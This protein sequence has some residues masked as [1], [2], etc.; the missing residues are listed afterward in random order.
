MQNEARK[1]R[2][3]R[4]SVTE[5]RRFLVVL[6]DKTLGLCVSVFELVEQGNLRHVV[7][8]GPVVAVGVQVAKTLFGSSRRLYTRDTE[9]A[10]CTGRGR[11]FRRKLNR[12]AFRNEGFS[13]RELFI[14]L[15]GE[16]VQACKLVITGIA[17]I[18]V[19]RGRL[20]VFYAHAGFEGVRGD[21]VQLRTQAV[22]HINHVVNARPVK[23]LAKVGN[24]RAVLFVL[25][26]RHG[27]QPFGQGLVLGP[28]CRFVYG[29]T[30]VFSVRVRVCVTGDIPVTKI[31]FRNLGGCNFYS[32][33][34]G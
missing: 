17:E 2:G 5:K 22:G 34:H 29:S 15:F 24:R 9:T 26:V 4:P 30:T 14:K 1:R 16:L 12:V 28:C 18:R 3:D 10:Y 7:G 21:T 13:E 31:L 20:R 33:F 11:K 27:K 23:P 19:K 32:C 25:T 6:D 8:V